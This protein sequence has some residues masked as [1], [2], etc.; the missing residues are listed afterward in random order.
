MFPLD[1]NTFIHPVIS[2][3]YFDKDNVNQQIG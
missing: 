3:F 1:C 2:D